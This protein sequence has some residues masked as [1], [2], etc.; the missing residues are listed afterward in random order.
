MKPIFIIS[1]VTAIILICG[2]MTLYM[3]NTES[4]R[5]YESLITV[6]ENIDSQIW[7]K[8][9]EELDKFHKRWDKISIYW[10]MLIDHY[11]IDY[12]ELELSQLSSF[13]KSEEKVEALARLSALKTLIKHIPDKE[14]FTLKNIL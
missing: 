4:E 7:E 9:E 3:L 12:I 5:L 2:V 6:E 10:S 1:I 13:I 11:E 14:A 8:A